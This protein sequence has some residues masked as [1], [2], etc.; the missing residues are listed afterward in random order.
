MSAQDRVSK[1][2]QGSES[3]DLMGLD[4]VRAKYYAVH[5]VHRPVP[6]LPTQ[7]AKPKEEVGDGIKTPAGWESWDGR[8][9]YRHITC[10][11]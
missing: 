5:G 6:T 2:V 9:R 10:K 7:K 11:D 4:S 1:K 8:R 3:I